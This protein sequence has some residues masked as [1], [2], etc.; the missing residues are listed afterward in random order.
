MAWRYERHHDINELRLVGNEQSFVL[1]F[2][3]FSFL[4][5]QCIRRGNPIV[6]ILTNV[7][8]TAACRVGVFCICTNRSPLEVPL[9]F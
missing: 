1:S 7:R 4:V 5:R 9:S 6:I 3:T 8:L 2:D